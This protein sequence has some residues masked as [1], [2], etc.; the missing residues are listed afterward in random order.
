[1]FLWKSMLQPVI[2]VW[3]VVHVRISVFVCVIL[4]T[5]SLPNSI[6]TPLFASWWKTQ[7]IAA[8]EASKR[9]GSEIIDSTQTK[10]H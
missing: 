4:S 6:L 9:T 8:M 3:N 5:A 10:K 2:L 1:M 7:R